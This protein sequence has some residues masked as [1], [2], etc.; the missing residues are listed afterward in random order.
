MTGTRTD[1][2]AVSDSVQPEP[3]TSNPAQLGDVV[4]FDVVVGLTLLGDIEDA[5]EE[6]G[7][8]YAEPV[9]D[10]VC[11]SAAVPRPLSCESQKLA[12][13]SRPFRTIHV[14]SPTS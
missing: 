7:L 2:L 13:W 3:P 6:L 5:S 10:V 12:V 14:V 11:R 8:I 1:L 4:V 9:S